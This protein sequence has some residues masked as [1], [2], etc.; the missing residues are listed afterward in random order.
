MSRHGWETTAPSSSEIHS[1]GDDE[2]SL[3]KIDITYGRFD[4]TFQVGLGIHTRFH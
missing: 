1:G 4:Q 2:I 3:Y